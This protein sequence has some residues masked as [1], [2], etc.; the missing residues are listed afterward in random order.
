M[1]SITE[2]TVS[3]RYPYYMLRVYDVNVSII[4]WLR[5]TIWIPLYPFGFILEGVVILRWVIDFNLCHWRYF[6]EVRTS[7]YYST[8]LVL[9]P[10]ST[11]MPITKVCNEG[12]LYSPKSDIPA[13]QS[14]TSMKP[15][16]SACL[17][18][19]HGTLPSTS[20]HYSG[21][22]SSSSSSQVSPFDPF[23]FFV[24]ERSYVS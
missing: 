16:S 12:L 1:Y 17:S 11:L 15:R 21:V 13:E 19:I 23:Q 2:T 4:T 18:P 20:P 10:H 22:T 5:Y 24:G 8:V 14:H 9:S 6:L 7:C 3:H